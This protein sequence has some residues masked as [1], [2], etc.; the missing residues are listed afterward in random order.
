MRVHEE[1]QHGEDKKRVKGRTKTQ[2]KR[3]LKTGVSFTDKSG[4][5]PKFSSKNEDN[6]TFES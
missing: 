3:G 2:S 4:M 6:R 5:D 1:N